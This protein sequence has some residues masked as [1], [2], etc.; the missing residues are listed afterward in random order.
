MLV[1]LIITLYFFLS[2]W[3]KAPKIPE[4]HLHPD[5]QTAQP[6]GQTDNPQTRN[7]KSMD[8]GEHTHAHSVART[9]SPIWSDF[10]AN[11]DLYLSSIV[12]NWY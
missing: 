8:L 2:D 4:G 9:H 3:N 6:P 5:T 12:F 10:S 1:V 11:R 7:S